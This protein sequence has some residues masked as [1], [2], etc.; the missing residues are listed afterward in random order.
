MQNM[1]KMN[2][3]KK[4]TASVNYAVKTL[5]RSNE[6]GWLALAGGST[7]LLQKPAHSRASAQTCPALVN[8]TGSSLHSPR[9]ASNTMC[10]F[11]SE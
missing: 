7:A 3:Q 6:G 4:S 10:R 2:F 9:S 8:R 1:R 11:H 5:S